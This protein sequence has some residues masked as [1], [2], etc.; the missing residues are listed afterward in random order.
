MSTIHIQWERE[1]V[2]SILSGSTLRFIII[3]IFSSSVTVVF[4]T[5]VK[6][7]A[8][9]SRCSR[10]D[11]S[12]LIIFFS[13]LFFFYTR[14]SLA[15]HKSL[16]ID[17]VCSGLCCGPA[18]PQNSPFFYEYYNCLRG[19]RWDSYC[20]SLNRLLFMLG[21]R[22]LLLKKP[23]SLKL[24]TIRSGWRRVN[25]EQKNRITTKTIFLQSL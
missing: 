24:P 4:I 23:R 18:P 5:S 25:Y 7:A 17:F 15:V 14:R 20:F 21:K 1:G 3:V 22:R 9:G 11:D 2:T 10:D 16:V 8:K 6:K 13:F 12:L 19:R